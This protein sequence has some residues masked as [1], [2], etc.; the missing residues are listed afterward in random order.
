MPKETR[1]GFVLEDE[2]EFSDAVLSCLCEVQRDIVYLIDRGYDLERSVTFVANRFQFSARQRTALTRA[3]SCSEAVYAR[4]EKR[5]GGMLTS[6]VMHIDGFNLII[7]L[8]AALSPGTTLLKCMD[9]TVRDLCGLHGTY[10]VIDATR[11]ALEFI[12]DTLKKREVAR[13]IFY[14]DAPVSNSGRLRAAIETVMAEHSQIAEVHMV[15]NAD[16][17]LRDKPYVVSS[18]SL[19]LDRCESWINFAREIIE[20]RLPGR[21]LVD[22][23]GH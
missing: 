12:A 17:E 3:T 21:R 16:A 8:E 14:L 1:R 10:R 22:L 18:D 6:Q 23:S 19:V 9:S 5:I 4:T 15:P 2:V 7:A 13:A 11:T 20:Q